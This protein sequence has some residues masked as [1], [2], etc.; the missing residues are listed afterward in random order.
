MKKERNVAKLFVLTSII[1]G[2]FIYAN[3]LLRMGSTIDIFD[4]T[5]ST[6]ILVYPFTF[7]IANIITREFEALDTIKA[8]LV[9]VMVQILIFWLGSLE[10][11]FAL[12]MVSCITFV[13]S[14]AVNLHVAGDLIAKG[15][16]K[17]VNWFM[18]Y[19]LVLALDNILHIV[20][21]SNYTP[22]VFLS[23]TVMVGLIIKTFISAF[24]GLGEILVLKRK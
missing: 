14:Q 7:Y 23:G 20:F 9:A 10:Y 19:V 12:I 17:Y 22:I 6:S 5:V 3:E 8:I 21:I 11:G 15:D 1:S 2:L 16:K 13:L 4:Y 18:L 24:L